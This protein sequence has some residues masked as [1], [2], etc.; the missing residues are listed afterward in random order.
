MSET[1]GRLHSLSEWARE[2]WNT[3]FEQILKTHHLRAGRSDPLLTTELIA[4]YML[5]FFSIT[6]FLGLDRSATDLLTACWAGSDSTPTQKLQQLNPY[7]TFFREVQRALH[8]RNQYLE[9]CLYNSGLF[10]K[11]SS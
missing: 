6:P 3:N 5:N 8:N 11:G 1:T 7:K 9:R 10:G 2:G 4:A